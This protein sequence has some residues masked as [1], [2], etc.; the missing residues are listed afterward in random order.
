VLKATILLG[1]VFGIFV[2]LAIC[3]AE[4]TVY[5]YKEWFF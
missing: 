3:F 4:E 2:F 5:W 1:I